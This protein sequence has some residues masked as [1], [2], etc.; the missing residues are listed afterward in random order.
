MTIHF[1]TVAKMGAGGILTGMAVRHLGV[2][3]P[4]TIVGLTVMGQAIAWMPDFVSR[5]LRAVRRPQT[6]PSLSTMPDEVLVA[7]QAS[8]E[9]P[10]HIRALSCVD[11]RQHG[12]IDPNRAA[13]Y[14]F[15]TRNSATLE[16][17]RALRAVNSDFS[18]PEK[19]FELDLS[20][21]NIT[22]DE[23]KYIIERFPNITKI[24]ASN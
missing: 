8:L 20:K 17:L 1:S 7:I 3:H 11:K 12:A 19:E 23:L 13:I 14:R 18:R 4:V 9:D 2:S 21:S 6:L 22:D 15:D 5:C 10:N 16:E 24:H